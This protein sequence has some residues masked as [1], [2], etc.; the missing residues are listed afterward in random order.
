MEVF[1]YDDNGKYIG[2]TKC[3]I[4]PLESRRAGK[5]IFLIPTKS[6]TKEPL[7]AKDGFTVLFMDDD[8]QYAAIP[9]PEPEPEPTQLEL[10]YQQLYECESNLAKYD[11]IGTKIATG[12]ATIEEYAEK[13]AQMTKWAEKIDEIKSLIAIEESKQSDV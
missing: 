5:D 7:P 10:L 9:E 11:Y 12:R 8:W 13:I 3:Q 4:D 1:L 6:T 2:T